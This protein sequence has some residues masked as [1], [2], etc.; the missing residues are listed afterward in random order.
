MA[1]WDLANAAYESKSFDFTSQDSVPETIR[2]KPDGTKL[3]MQGSAADAI[4]QYSAS[5]PWDISTLTYDGVVLDTTAQNDSPQGFCWGDDG[6]KLYVVA[7]GS[8]L[9]AV[10]EYTATGAYDLSTVTYASRTESVAAADQQAMGVE[11]KP[12]GTKFWIIGIQNDRVHSFSCSTPWQLGA[13]SSNDGISFSV[14]AETASPLGFRWK[15][16]GTKFYVV[17]GNALLASV[18]EYS[19]GTPWDIT[20]ASYTGVSYTSAEHNATE[21]VHFKDDGT[22]M[23]LLGTDG[24]GRQYSF[25]EAATWHMGVGMSIGA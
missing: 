12:D 17:D 13:S 15:P 18:F 8:L 25:A 4:Y 16:D 5:T 10:Y 23:Y 20:T 2:W 6:L 21:D 3:Y 11:F 19:L 14:S 7:I 9:D 24:T 22:Q 1:A